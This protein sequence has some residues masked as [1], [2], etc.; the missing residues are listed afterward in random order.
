MG[1]PYDGD[2]MKLRIHRSKWLRGESDSYLVR[3]AD[4]K[5][6]CLGFFGCALGIKKQRM[7]GHSNPDSVNSKLWPEWAQSYRFGTFVSRVTLNDLII[8]ND[9][10]RMGESDREEK[11]KA[12]FKSKGVEVEFI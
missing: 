1:L 9:D 2:A 5:M 4:N 8:T 11:I 10:P 6:C 12:L 3:R 7:L